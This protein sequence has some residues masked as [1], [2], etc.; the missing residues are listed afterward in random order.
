MDVEYN[1]HSCVPLLPKPSHSS[2]DLTQLHG[3]GVRYLK[4]VGQSQVLLGNWPTS[5]FWEQLGYCSPYHLNS[6]QGQIDTRNGNA[7][8]MR[9]RR[10]MVERLKIPTP[11]D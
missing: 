5:L 3:R 9:Q 6:G 8:E 7:L 11:Q 10:K 4:E 2:S 1:W